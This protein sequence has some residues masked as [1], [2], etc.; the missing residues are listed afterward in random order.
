MNHRNETFGSGFSE[1]GSAG[2]AAT[3]CFLKKEKSN[4][5]RQ[6]LGHKKKVRSG[7]P[8]VH[9]PG[10]HSLPALFP[11]QKKGKKRTSGTKGN[12]LI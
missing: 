6:F 12:Y 3:Y 2:F 10:E 8:T 11:L 9:S 5:G 4:R 1:S 7:G